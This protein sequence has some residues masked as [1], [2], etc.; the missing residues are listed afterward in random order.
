MYP[1]DRWLVRIFGFLTAVGVLWLGVDLL[2]YS[3]VV[4]FSNYILLEQAGWLWLGLAVML[5][6]SLRYLV[7]RLQPPRM[8]AF[9]RETETGQIRI[10]EQAVKEIALRAAKPIIGVGRMQIKLA[11]DERGLVIYLSVQAEPKDLNAMSEELQRT[12]QKSVG[13]MTSLKVAAVN[14]HVADLAPEPAQKL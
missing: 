1:F 14:V 6:L 5:I 7:F 11:G 10:G 8:R 13:E 3:P 4:K 12:V 2:H 9:I